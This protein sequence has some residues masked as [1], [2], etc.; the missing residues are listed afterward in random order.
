MKHE[1]TATVSVCVTAVLLLF[2]HLKVK[3]EEITTQ[4][5]SPYYNSN[6]FTI[7]EPLFYL[8]YPKGFSLSICGKK[9]LSHYIIW[10]RNIGFVL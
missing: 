2:T 9:L 1:L 3:T 7:P 8:L 10:I 6:T 4:H 5:V